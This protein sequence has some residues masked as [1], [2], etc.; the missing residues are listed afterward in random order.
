MSDAQ[1]V[2]R[3]VG[4]GLSIVV[5]LQYGIFLIVLPRS[6]SLVAVAVTVA[7]LL[8]VQKAYARTESTS[9]MP[10]L[11]LWHVIVLAIAA[12]AIG[13]ALFWRFVI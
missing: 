4:L 2:L 5:G 1:L 13:P 12:I 10:S 3:R 8:V 7:L 6:I 9:N 11:S